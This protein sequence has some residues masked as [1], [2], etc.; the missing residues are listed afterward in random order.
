MGYWGEIH[1]PS[2]PDIPWIRF[3]TVLYKGIHLKRNS[4]LLDDYDNPIDKHDTR[5]YVDILSVSYKS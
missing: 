4:K 5:K 2:Y 1:M 3:A